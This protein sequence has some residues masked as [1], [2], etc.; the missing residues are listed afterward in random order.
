MPSIPWLEWL[1]TARPSGVFVRH[2]LMV[3]SQLSATAPVAIETGHLSEKQD[4][5]PQA[6]ERGVSTG[7]NQSDGNGVGRFGRSTLS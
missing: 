5:W 6:A 7:G 4:P 3:S 1:A 2:P